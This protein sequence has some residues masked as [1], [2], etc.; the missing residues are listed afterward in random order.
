VLTFVLWDDIIA[1]LSQMTAQQNTSYEGN[2]SEN[3]HIKAVEKIKKLL[4]ST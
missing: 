2:S 3:H 1:E 4:T